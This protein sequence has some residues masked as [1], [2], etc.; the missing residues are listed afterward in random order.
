MQF[1]ICL[2]GDP[3][4]HAMIPEIQAMK[5]GV[6]LNGYGLAGIKSEGEWRQR[7]A[8]HLEFTRSFHGPLAVHGP[9]I[10]MRFNH[11]DH[12]LREAVDRRMDVFFDTARQLGVRTVVLH[13]GY[14]GSVE[15]YRLKWLEENTQYWRREAVRWKTLGVRIV[16]ENEEE[17]SPDLMV[18]LVER[19]DSDSL[20]LCL[21]V[22]HANISS[23]LSLAE[24]VERMGSRLWHVHLHDNDGKEDQHLAVG[25][26]NIGFA[27]FFAALGRIAP[28]ASVAL[29]SRIDGPAK[30]ENLKVAMRYAAME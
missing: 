1:M 10:G 16:L 24:W 2:T 5:L 26:G 22:G 13:T 15:R 3:E 6:E 8:I 7:L 28:H 9:F 30:L 11:T 19:V 29:E 25:R 12:I 14:D 17:K 18:Q 21:D 23:H 20:G 27:P 4:Q